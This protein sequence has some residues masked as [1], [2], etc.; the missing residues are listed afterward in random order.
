MVPKIAETDYFR[1]SDNKEY[2]KRDTIP[3]FGSI[4]AQLSIAFSTVLFLLGIGTVSYRILE[5]WTW[6]KCFYFS[7]T[8]LTTVGYGDLHPSSELSRLFTSIYILVGVT[9][10]V[11]AIGI[12]GSNFIARR[13]RMLMEK[14]GKKGK[15][16]K[17][18][19]SL[20]DHG[21]ILNW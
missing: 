15:R 19:R 14:K 5:G 9:F 7:V 3:M 20:P 11:G 2:Q 12:I 6:I 18:Q 13:E 4:K 8:T 21:L 1:N 16:S 10:T 17:R